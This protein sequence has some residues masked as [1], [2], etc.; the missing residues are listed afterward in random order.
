MTILGFIEN[1]FNCIRSLI[2]VFHVCIYPNPELRTVCDTRSAGYNLEYFLLL[3]WLPYPVTRAGDR[4]DESMPFPWPLLGIQKEPRKGFENDSLIL[5]PTTR[6]VT[7]N[8][9]TLL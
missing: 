1:P 5:F 2:H 3:D 8:V 9:F 7:L 6:T 4:K